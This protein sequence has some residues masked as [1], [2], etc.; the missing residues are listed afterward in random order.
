MSERSRATEKIQ[1]IPCPDGPML[2]RGATYIRDADGRR[3]AVERPVVA[4]CRCGA[5]TNA[6]WCDGMH[7]L[8]QR[9]A[10]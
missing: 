5:S 9:A 8:L 4:V 2:V 7:K 10:Q 6:P 1:Y 3:H